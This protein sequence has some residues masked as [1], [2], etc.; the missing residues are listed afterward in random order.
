MTVSYRCKVT[1]EAFNMEKKE[2]VQVSLKNAMTKLLDENR[3]E[4]ITVS[5]LCKT[6]GTSRVTFYTY[7]DD[8]YA[9]L[10][11]YFKDM[12]DKAEKDFEEL[13]KENNPKDEPETA[14]CNFLDAVL[15]LYYDRIDF[16]TH[17]EEGQN[18]N[19]YFRYYWYV[20]SGFEKFTMRYC[21]VLKPV[22]SLEQT[23][24]TVCNALWGMIHTCRAEKMPVDR[25]RKRAKEAL[26]IL[27]ESGFFVK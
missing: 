7:Y 12:L 8:K 3:F 25:I 2:N 26:K 14:Y 18:Q 6:A 19:L 4:H 16:F 21:E 17:A 15:N 11:D 9:L 23:S 20:L 27:I 22:F 5:E 24:A 10:D 1:D 13:Q